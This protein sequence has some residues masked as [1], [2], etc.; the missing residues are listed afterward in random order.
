MKFG[1]LALETLLLVQMLEAGSPTVL[2]GIFTAVV[3]SN[4]LSCAVV[5]F[6]P[7]ERAPLAEILL[8]IL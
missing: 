6:V 8:D 4:A 2:L 5:M 1:D 3:T 7:Y